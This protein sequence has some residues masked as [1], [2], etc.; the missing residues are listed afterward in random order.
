MLQQNGIAQHQVRCGEACDLVQRE[1]PRHDAQK[2]AYGQLLDDGLAAGE[3]LDLLV[4]R[5]GRALGSEVFEDLLA[6]LGLAHRL[7][8]RFAHLGGHDLA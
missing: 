4:R 2:R 5:E 1:V 3:G 6:E 7:G 8:Q